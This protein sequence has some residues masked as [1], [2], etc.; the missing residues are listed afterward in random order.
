MHLLKQG[1]VML[2]NSKF[3]PNPSV[4]VSSPVGLTISDS[5]IGMATAYS[6]S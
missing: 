2:F 3:V 1:V 5:V 4:N 6:M